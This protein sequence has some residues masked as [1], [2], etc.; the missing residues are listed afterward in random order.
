MC[1]ILYEYREIG[2]KN[3][4]KRIFRLS[5]ETIKVWL[6]IECY[7][8]YTGLY[9]AIDNNTYVIYI[10]ILPSVIFDRREDVSSTTYPFQ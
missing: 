2:T 9:N 10:E 3:R 5:C 1:P 8:I 7:F 6:V 4:G